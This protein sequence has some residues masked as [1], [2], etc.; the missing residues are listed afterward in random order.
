MREVRIVNLDG[1]WEEFKKAI[2]AGNEVRFKTRSEF[3]RW[4]RRL[5]LKKPTEG[6][7]VA[8]FP[9]KALRFLFRDMGGVFAVELPITRNLYYEMMRDNSG[10]QKGKYATMKLST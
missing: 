5:L 2:D 7:E 4:L 10:K 6:V 3:D 1:L 8:Y 9:G